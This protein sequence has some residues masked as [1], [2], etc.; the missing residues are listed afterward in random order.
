MKP[1]E[2]IM[3]VVCF[4]MGCGGEANQKIDIDS[5]KGN[6]PTAPITPPTD[7]LRI[8]STKSQPND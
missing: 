6:L 4:A 2:F 5:I 7:T 1:L 3:V 8:D